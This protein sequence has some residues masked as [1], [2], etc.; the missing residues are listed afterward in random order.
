[1]LECFFLGMGGP[2]HWSHCPCWNPSQSCTF[3]NWRGSCRSCTFLPC[4]AVWPPDQSYC[5][6]VLLLGH[7]SLLL[8]A[9]PL[10]HLVEEPVCLSYFASLFSDLKSSPSSCQL[11]P[12]LVYPCPVS[13]LVVCPVLCPVMSFVIVVLVVKSQGAASALLLWPFC[14]PSP[15]WTSLMGLQRDVGHWTYSTYTHMKFLCRVSWGWVGLHQFCCI[16]SCHSLVCYT[17]LF[18]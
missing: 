6:L 1:M 17:C 13:Y 15:H 5:T 14:H 16:Q 18:L 2:S 4:A 12:S 11:G 8:H 7:P 3:C 9:L 10:V